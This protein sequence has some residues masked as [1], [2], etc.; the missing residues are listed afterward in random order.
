LTEIEDIAD[1]TAA[2]IALAYRSGAAGPVAVTECLLDRI[3]RARGDNVFITVMADRARA[4]AR[5]AEAR[6]KAG[7]RLSA[8]DGIPV[9]WKDNIDVAG[10]PTT[11]ASRLF[12]NAEAK[13]AD[14][15]CVV[16]AAAAGM[17][18][19]GKLNMTEL[20][21]SGLG[22]NPHYGTPVNPNDRSTLRSPGGSS[23]GAGAA[24]AARLTP[25]AIGSDT[26]GSIRI[27][28]AFNGVVGFKPSEN[29]IDKAGTVPLSRTLDTIGPLARSVADCVLLDMALRGVVAADVR[30]ESLRGLPILV[31]TNVVL[32]QAEPAV[33][34]N[35]EHSLEALAAAGAVIRRERVAAFDEAVE[36]TAQHGSL[37][38]A[39]AY[40][41]YR[42][43]VES[44]RVVAMD[45]RVIHRIMGGKRMSAYDLLALQDGRRRL[46]ADAKRQIGGCV[47]AMPTT[48][49]TAP[50]VAPL[51]ADDE[52]F[53]RVN[54]LTLRNTMLGN[55]LMLCGL[56]LPNGRDGNGMPT[57]LLVSAAHGEDDKLL[58]YGLEIERILGTV[59]VT[60]AA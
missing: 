36:L 16:H 1:R 17:V 12:G 6:F 21:Y 49:I 39:E 55:I 44:D 33:L 50:E 56:A 30:R 54:L 45:R 19:L 59:T 47:L 28:A 14:Q 53:H 22:L 42:D 46:V 40:H 25:C 26:G 38:A 13:T 7:R 41:E 37:T 23:S 11:A 27:P 8:L 4:E 48:A 32:D 20:A 52:L 58:S 29:R 18:S 34:K 10:A 15:V 57:S 60:A 35:F 24:V 9:A 31:P 5:Q 3:E 51:E 43:I 2:E